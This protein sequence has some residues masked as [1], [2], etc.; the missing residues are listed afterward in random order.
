MR[1]K[2][3][4]SFCL[5][6]APICALGKHCQLPFVIPLRRFALGK[7]IG[8]CYANSSKFQCF[9]L[10][11]DP[12]NAN[13][14]IRI[15]NLL[16]QFF[17]VGLRPMSTKLAIVIQRRVKRKRFRTSSVLIDPTTANHAIRVG[18]SLFQFCCLIAPDKR[19][20]RQWLLNVAHCANSSDSKCFW[21]G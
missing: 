11:V 4:S 7:E 5:S 12:T 17:V 20:H 1:T 3:G 21:F 19:K 10:S 13:H 16:V 18:N 15:S 8:D 9:D 14:V 6:C 2:D